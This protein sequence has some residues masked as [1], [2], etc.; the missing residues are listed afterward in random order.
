MTKNPNT[1]YFE[2]ALQISLSQKKEEKIKRG[3]SC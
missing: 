3:E 2:D 1:C